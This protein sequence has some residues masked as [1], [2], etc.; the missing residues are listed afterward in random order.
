MRESPKL[1]YVRTPTTRYDPCVRACDHIANLQLKQFN[2]GKYCGRW[3]KLGCFDV[4]PSPM[5]SLFGIIS[6]TTS[7]YLPK[8]PLGGSQ[9]I[10]TWLAVV[11]DITWNVVSFF[12]YSFWSLHRIKNNSVHVRLFQLRKCGFEK[13]E[14]KETIAVNVNFHETFASCQKMVYG[15]SRNEWEGR[16]IM[17]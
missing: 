16:Y 11:P 13:I 5:S 1:I 8:S 10:S 9:R 15:L 6:S 7:V 17:P 3:M 2:T 12:F 14:T 4:I